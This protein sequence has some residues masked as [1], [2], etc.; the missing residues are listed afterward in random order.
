MRRVP[1]WVFSTGDPTCAGARCRSPSFSSSCCAQR[2]RASAPAARS[3]TRSARSTQRSPRRWSTRPASRS[4]PL[5][6]R[7]GRS[8]RHPRRPEFLQTLPHVHSHGRILHRTPARLGV[9]ASKPWSSASSSARSSSPSTAAAR[10]DPN[11]IVGAVV[12]E[13][14]RDRGRGLA[15]AQGR[16]ARRGRRPRG[17][18]RAGPRRDGVRDARALRAPRSDAAV[19]RRA[20]RSRRCRAS[21]S[22]SSIRIRRTVAVSSGSARAAST[23]GSPT[24]ELALPLPPADRGVAD[25]GRRRGGRS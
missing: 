6:R 16:P 25:V 17:C 15:R 3:S 9:V 18:G 20:A 19:C 14:R 2:P 4:I 5:W 1:G 11:P 8:F 7:S 22:V 21:S 13:R 10:R 24:D 12:V 23:C